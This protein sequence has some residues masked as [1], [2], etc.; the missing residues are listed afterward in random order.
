M[1]PDGP[2]LPDL[3]VSEGWAKLRD[4]AGRKDDSDESQAILDKLQVLEARAKADSKGLWAGSG[5]RV[6]TTY[7]LPD[8]KAFAE[9]WK[10]KQ[11]DGECIRLD[12]CRM[13][14][15]ADCAKQSSKRS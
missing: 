7:E 6:Q 2:Q 3:V 15:G 1:L 10:G 4:D 12:T 14:T 9:A 13:R 11:L 8:A 5:G